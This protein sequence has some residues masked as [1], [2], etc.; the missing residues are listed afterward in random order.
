MA[1]GLLIVDVQ[2]DYFPGGKWEL[3]GSENAGQ[4]AGSL[5]KFFR[6]HKLPVL[7][8]Q[9]IGQP[10]SPFFVPYTPGV[11]IHTAVFPQSGE[12]LVQKQYPNAFRETALLD[13]LRKQAIK[14]LVVTGMMTHMCVDAAVRAATDFGFE[15]QVAQD[16]CATRDL[17]LNG[18]V[19][20]ASEVH[21]AF[22]AA[23]N[24]TYAKVMS[25]DRIMTGLQEQS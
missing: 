9:H 5:L 16:G 8:V 21:D 14:Q 19:L 6:D 2:N 20:P 11:T 1:V 10:D 25:A 22:L 7:H 3:V 18:K 15:C 12:V 17:N 23:L 13:H 24:G 4:V